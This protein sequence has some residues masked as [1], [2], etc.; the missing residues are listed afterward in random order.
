[1]SQDQAVKVMAKGTS[2]ML[3]GGMLRTFNTGV[4]GNASKSL[5]ENLQINSF[6][7]MLNMDDDPLWNKYGSL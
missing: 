5:A 4:N 6:H 2:C 3:G 1:M 7:Y